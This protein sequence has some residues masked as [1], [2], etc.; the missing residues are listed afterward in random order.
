VAGAHAADGAFFVATDAVPPDATA[1]VDEGHLTD[2][3]SERL[4]EIVAAAVRASVK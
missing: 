2:A 1:F 4:A 3:G